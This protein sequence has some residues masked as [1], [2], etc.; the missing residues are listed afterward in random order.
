[1]LVMV[2]SLAVPSALMAWALGVWGIGTQPDSLT[3]FGIAR[4]ASA[5][6]GFVAAPGSLTPWSVGHFPPGYPAVLAVGLV[7]G[8][9]VES[10]A[11][12]VAIVGCGLLAFV[13]ATGVRHQTG[14][15]WAALTVAALTGLTPSVLNLHARALSETVSTI[16]CVVSIMAV[17][18]AT[19]R[20]SLS[21]V[22]LAGVLTG[23][24]WLTRYNGSAFVAGGL[25]FVAWAWGGP[26]RSRLLPCSLYL[27][28][29]VAMMGSWYARNWM[30]SG[31]TTDFALAY[32]P[33]TGAEVREVL[34][35]MRGWLI[36]VEMPAKWSAVVILGVLMLLALAAKA[37]GRTGKT[38]NA[39]SMPECALL[40]AC[41]YAAMVVFGDLWLS[42][43]P[44][45]ER[46][47]TPMFVLISLWGVCIVH[48]MATEDPARWRRLGIAAGVLLVSLGVVGSVAWAQ[49]VRLT[50]GQGEYNG[51][52]WQRSRLVNWLKA[53]PHEV[54]IFTNGPTAL[55]YVTGRPA[56]GIPLRRDK[57]TLLDDDRYESSLQE[58]ARSLRSKGGYV[59]WFARHR[60]YDPRLA[61]ETDV[62][63]RLKVRAIRRFEDGTVYGL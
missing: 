28:S 38:N 15:I 54:P 13:C 14:S 30:L 45:N 63:K 58:I 20:H 3:Y 16:L 9:P 33:M 34:T 37:S 42:A 4:N 55:S 7:A 5:G 61:N 12:L 41:A 39:P 59:V 6:K 17:A 36:P 25:L 8:Y 44:I 53:V 19:S 50:G 32:H 56:S 23:L 21:G 29:P 57:Y 62:V 2:L 24:A 10:V 27:V 18:R 22:L 35:V 48:R 26:L 47:L 51:P 52:K 1:M 31:H 49:H 11:W 60:I 46:Y 43:G 40:T